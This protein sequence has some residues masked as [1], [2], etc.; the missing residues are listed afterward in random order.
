MEEAVERDGGGAGLIARR[1]RLHGG[2]LPVSRQAHVRPGAK[3][4]DPSRLFNAS[5]DG[6]ARRAIDIPE[7]TE[8]DADA[9]K[10]LVKAAVAQN[11]LFRPSARPVKLLAGGN[12]QIPKADGDAPVRAYIDA[13]PGWKGDVGR[14]LD[15]LILRTVPAA[16][17]AIKWNTPFYGVEGLGWFLGFHCLTK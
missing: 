16:R 8:V 1:G 3:L 11:G 10:A 6:N 4:P 17:K 2:D 14:W 9:F 12:P 7:G 15:S 5:L 13:M